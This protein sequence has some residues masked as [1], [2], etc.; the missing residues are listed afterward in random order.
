MWHVIPAERVHAGISLTIRYLA[1]ASQKLEIYFHL[2]D[3]SPVSPRS[4]GMIDRAIIIGKS[5]VL[6]FHLSM[7]AFDT[8]I[9]LSMC[10]RG[11]STRL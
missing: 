11:S 8:A 1:F 4:I 10:N 7:E 5:F 6:T 3:V 2:F 9:S